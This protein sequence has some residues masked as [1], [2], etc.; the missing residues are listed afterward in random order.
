MSRKW[1]LLLMGE[2]HLR[3][4]YVRL[5]DRRGHDVQTSRDISDADR[6]IRGGNLDL[7]VI[8]SDLD[9]EAISSHL[10][11]WTAL[12][13]AP[14]L[15][16]LTTP[17][18]GDAAEDAALRSTPPLD[19]DLVLQKPIAPMEFGI[20]IDQMLDNEQP[21]TLQRDSIIER[22]F[23]AIQQEFV[24]QLDQD[25]HHLEELWNRFCEC[26]DSPQRSAMRL[27]RTVAPIRSAARQFGF[28]ELADDLEG[29]ESFLD[30][31]LLP[32]A[33][34]HDDQ[35]QRGH[36]LLEALRTS[37]QQLQVHHPAVAPLTHAQEKPRTL[38]VIDP[39]EQFLERIEAFSDQFM[40]RVRTARDIDEALP[41]VRTPLVTGVILSISATSSPASLRDSIDELRDAS[42]LSPL[43]VAL[44]GENSEQLD[45]VRGLWAGASAL[46]SKPLTASTFSRV[47][48]RLA[49]LHRAQ[50]SSLLVI[51]PDEDFAGF[52]ATHLETRHTAVH[53]HDQPRS[54]FEELER[55]RPDLL[56]LSTHVRGVSAFDVCRALRAI[57]R[58]R[59]LPIVLTARRRQ[60]ETRLAAYQ[61]GAD[62]M[63]CHQISSEELRARIRVRLERIRMLRER[64]D[65]DSLTGLLTRRAFLEQLAAR[66]SGAERHKRPLAF[67]LLDIDHFKQVNDT[68]GHP[69]GDQVLR[70]LGQLLRDCFRIEDLRA[71]WGGE[72]FAVVLVDETTST[73]EQALER[74]LAEFSDIR[75]TGADDESFQVTFSGGIAQYPID[76]RD[77]EVLL[78][79][80]DAR[81]LRAKE[82]GRNQ[83]VTG[84]D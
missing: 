39:D 42:P 29:F 45:N 82:G 69:A 10:E 28:A 56:L 36:A 4:L 23:D 61:C 80:A 65:R 25:L 53:Y 49:A 48:S 43:P 27:R 44:M 21:S 31:F 63:I 33:Q 52:L 77:P 62:D 72:E 59:P 68:Y 7:A 16:L 32:E 22:E 55:H 8:D 54:L 5:L 73:A 78:S 57:P 11:E 64:A 47:T 41:Q 17:E 1:V 79:T 26:T 9:E 70:K 24:S 84:G 35:L 3:R 76:G 6:L 18:S 30:P 51:E 20:Q 71:R 81:L 58:W 15:V 12:D 67:A 60:P 50:K 19:V 75:F 46:I 83:L 13:E 74:V 2:P 38:L 66:L 40:L 37:S 34:V 14:P